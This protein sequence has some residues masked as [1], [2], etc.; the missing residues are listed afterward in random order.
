MF[1]RRLPPFDYQAPT[2]LAEALKLLKKYG[3]KAS[4]LAGGTDLL[5]AM[6]KRALTPAYLINVKNIAA[7]QG[8]SYDD[9]QGLT[10]G[11]LVTCAELEESPLIKEKAPALWDAACVMASPQVKTLATIGGNLCSAVPSADTAPP[12]IALGAEAVLSGPKGERTLLVE[13]LFKGPAAAH[14]ARNEILTHI[15]IPKQPERSSTAYLKLMRRAALD[16]AL[17]G[18]A[19]YICLDTA[20]TTCKEARIALGA[21][22]PTPMRAPMAEKLLTGKDVTEAVAH[23]AGEVA[24]TVCSPITDVRASLA[25]RCS[26]VEVLTKRAVMA[27][28]ARIT[29]GRERI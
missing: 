12:L 17:V 19:A 29:N 2:S 20:T 23:E 3:G 16:L 9:Q 10:I 21:V 7:L 13:K 1:I 6:K 18:V 8:I 28:F 4:I 24:G 26:M 15:L 22:A 11:A 25:Y 27:A 14:L 5:L